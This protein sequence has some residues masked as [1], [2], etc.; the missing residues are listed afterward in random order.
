MDWTHRPV[1][2][3]LAL[4]HDEMKWTKERQVD[5][6]HRPVEKVLALVHDEVSGLRWG[7]RT[8]VPSIVLLARCMVIIYNI[9][10]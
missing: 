4:V 7:K 10:V 9:A 1:K 8:K 6:T 5:C 2:K 3:V